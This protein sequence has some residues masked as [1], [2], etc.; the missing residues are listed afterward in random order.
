MQRLLHLV[1]VA[2]LTFG[3][4]FCLGHLIDFAWDDNMMNRIV[5]IALSPLQLSPYLIALA[6]DAA[7]LILWFICI[8]ALCIFYTA[9]LHEIPRPQR[10][11][12]ILG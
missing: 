3:F 1:L 10:K 6:V 9:C 2:A 5:T 8:P 4:M 11:S 12:N 7:Y